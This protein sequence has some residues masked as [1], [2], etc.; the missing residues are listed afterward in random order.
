MFLKQ[1]L[2]NFIMKTKPQKIQKIPLN[3]IRLTQMFNP[4]LLIKIRVVV[5]VVVQKLLWFLIKNLLLVG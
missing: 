2:N 4:F 5:R 3:W 1:F